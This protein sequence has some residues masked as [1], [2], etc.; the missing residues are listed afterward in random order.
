M[1]NRIFL[2]FYSR[3]KLYSAYE[4]LEH[5]FDVRVRCVATALYAPSLA[6][7]AA[8]GGTVDLYVTIIALG[9]FGTVHTALGGM[10]GRHLDRRGPIL[11]AF[12]RDD[13]GGGLDRD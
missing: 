6:L 9:V 4:Y 13:P 3:M 12:R 2:P 11:G 8:T 7:W 1:V 10:N 5:R